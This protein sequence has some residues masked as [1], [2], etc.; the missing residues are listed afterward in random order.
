M[1]RPHFLYL[2]WRFF[3]DDEAEKAS[4]QG[5]PAGKAVEATSDAVDEMDADARD[6]YY[7]GIGDVSDD[8]PKRPAPSGRRN[9]SNV[10]RRSRKN[11]RAK[12]N[13]ERKRSKP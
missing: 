11:K 13:G 1:C 5:R 6:E 10:T 8:T 4:K 9:G 3:D 12:L 7:F 2:D